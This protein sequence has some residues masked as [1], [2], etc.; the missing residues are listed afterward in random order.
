MDYSKLVE[1]YQKLES[2]TKGLEKTFWISKL[3]KHTKEQDLEVIILLV[4]GR[5]YPRT[6]EVK[7]GVA[8]QMAIKA[9][10]KSTGIGE[11][12]IKDEWR[13][14]GDLGKVAKKLIAKKKQ[15]TLFSTKLTVK[16]VFDNLR[17]L[18]FVTGAGSVD[19]KIGLVSE[20]LTSAK[21][22]EANYIIKTVLEDL[23]V[24]V[25]EGTLRDAIVWAF[26]PPAKGILFKC[27]KCGSI[28]PKTSKCLECSNEIDTKIKD[29]EREKYNHYVSVVQEAYDVLNNF[30]KVALLA[31]TKGES[32]LKKT[33][34][35]LGK[36]IKVMLAIKEATL[37]DAIE[38]V[39]KPCEVEYKLDGFRMQ[40]HKDGDIVK[41]FTRRL[42]EV[43]KQFPEVVEYVKKYIKAKNCLL[44]SEAVG[45]DPKTHKYLPFQQ[46]SQRIRRKYDIDKMAKELPVELDVF[47][48]LYYNGESTIKLPLKDRLKIVKK[49]VEN[50]KRKIVVV[51]SLISDKE[52]E[53]EKF[54][55]ESLAA[56]NEGI[57]LKNLE[58][59]YKPG[60]RVGH[61]VKFKPVLES[62]D[63]VIVGAEWGT[64]KR[65]GWLSSFNLACRDGAKLLNIGKVGT[66]FKEKEPGLTFKKM[67]EMLKPLII[68]EHGRVVKVKPKIVIEVIYEEIQKSPT[69]SSGF[70]LRFPRVVRI[71]EDKGPSEASE[72][73]FIE[74]IYRTQK[75]R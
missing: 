62:L 58:S 44:D 61:M 54:Y 7:T 42:D 35:A 66:G 51:E 41:I 26:F 68:E 22:D 21:P 64:G 29:A 36:P 23:R 74:Q 39:G 34:T 12:E 15:S 11:K 71:R 38:R 63:L 60:S 18:P 65:G 50:H 37:H 69:Y 16:K 2:T 5:V 75:A 28:N 9:I 32:G 73:P 33:Q 56:G 24:G 70:A 10:S 8:S 55:K 67:T 31:K 27:S 46:I 49:I 6:D 40:I 19:K 45:F 17:K 48:I 53:I 43:T 59:P 14:I 20:L 3:L 30:S 4:Q 13:K 25:G 47:D 1:V 57:M 52:K 72:L